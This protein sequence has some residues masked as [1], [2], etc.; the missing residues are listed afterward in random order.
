MVG[1]HGKAAC[2]L[3]LEDMHV[4]AGADQA[5]SRAQ[6]GRKTYMQWQLFEHH[7]QHLSYLQRG[8]CAAR[9]YSV[10]PTGRPPH[11]ASH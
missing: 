7:I 10:W 5:A 11:A 3:Y 2:S 8:I 6:V 9:Y 4:H 1:I